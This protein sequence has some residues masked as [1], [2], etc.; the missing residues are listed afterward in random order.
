MQGLEMFDVPPFREER[1]RILPFIYLIKLLP[2]TSSNPA[3]KIKI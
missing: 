3:K 2:K 1:E